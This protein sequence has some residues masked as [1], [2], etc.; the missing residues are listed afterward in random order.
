MRGS[1]AGDGAESLREDILTLMRRLNETPS[2][3]MTAMSI[4][5]GDYDDATGISPEEVRTMITAGRYDSIDTV[6]RRAADR[7]EVDP[8][9]VSRR[10]RSLPFTLLRDELMIGMREVADDVLVEIVDTIFLPLV[11][12]PPV[13][14]PGTASVNSGLS[15]AQAD[16]EGQLSPG[17]EAGGTDHGDRSIDRE[18]PWARG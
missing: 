9:R 3:V 2:R 18:V 4:L 15:L 8:V 14:E 13:T 12:P 11:Q 6:I 16:V 7:G 17:G 5:I 10:I 1:F